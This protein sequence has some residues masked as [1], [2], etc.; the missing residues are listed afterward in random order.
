MVFTMQ[1]FNELS[2]AQLQE[3]AGNQA[4]ALA[5]KDEKLAEQSKEVL[6]RDDVIQQLEAKIEELEKDYLKLWKERFDAKSERYIEDPNQLKLDYGDTDEAADAAEGL[7]DALEEQEIEI[8]EHKRRKRKK[9]NESLPAHL[10]RIVSVVDAEDA[11]KT[12]PEHGEKKLLPEAMWDVL[13]KL[14]Y[15]PPSL[16]VEVK[17][18]Q[19]YACDGQPACRHRVG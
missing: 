1:D 2:R 15:V 14:V 16:Y 18:Y 4:A 12:C 8:P 7:A 13:E 10:P 19:K 6:R 9:R 17:K 5:V 11:D 3:L